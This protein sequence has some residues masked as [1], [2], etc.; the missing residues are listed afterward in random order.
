[1]MNVQNKW[2]HNSADI[3]DKI[4][5][6]MLTAA[7]NVYNSSFL[8]CISYFISLY[9]S[10]PLA[11]TRKSSFIGNVQSIMSSV[12]IFSGYLVEFT[13]NLNSCCCFN[14]SRSIWRI[15]NNPG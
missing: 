15:A 8:C 4:N 3:T 11:A 5:L 1:M 2:Q 10:G 9:P 12:A 7:I 6:N 14:V 13:V